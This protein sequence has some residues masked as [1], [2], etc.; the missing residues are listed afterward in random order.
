MA[1]P[2]RNAFTFGVT[3]FIRPIGSP[4]TM[5]SP[6]MAPSSAIWLGDT[7]PAW[8]WPP[9]RAGTRRPVAGTAGDDGRLHQQVVEF[10][11]LDTLDQ[12]GDLSPGVDQGRALGVP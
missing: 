10:P 12:G 7:G 1:V 6:A 8:H 11:A 3:A 9:R 4:R 5:V 2:F